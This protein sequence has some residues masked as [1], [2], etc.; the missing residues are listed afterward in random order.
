[1]PVLFTSE[2]ILMNCGGNLGYPDGSLFVMTDD[3]A[4]DLLD[5]CNYDLCAVCSRLM[6]PVNAWTGQKVFLVQI[7]SICVKNLRVPSGNETGVDANWIPGGLHPS[8]FKQAV[9]EPVALK[10]CD[11]MEVQ[12][13]S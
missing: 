6:V 11:V 10:D 13:K 5:S 4:S 8:G 3:E 7:P 9:I 12:W 1:M 2:S